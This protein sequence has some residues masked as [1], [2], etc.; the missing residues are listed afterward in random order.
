MLTLGHMFK[1]Q[2]RAK[3]PDDMLNNVK[4]PK[5]HGLRP[6]GALW[7]VAAESHVG[8]WCPA[9]AAGYPPEQ[10]VCRDF[11]RGRLGLCWCRCCG[12]HDRAGAALL[13]LPCAKRRLSC[14]RNAPL[15]Q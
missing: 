5:A 4:H 1:P 2:R 11:P 10:D 9:C 14:R 6:W 12:G 8:V 15:R 3:N 13:L 7:K